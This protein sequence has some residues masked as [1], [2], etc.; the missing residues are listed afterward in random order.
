MLFGL[1]TEQQ[2]SPGFDYEIPSPFEPI[3]DLDL[4]IEPSMQSGIGKRAWDHA[5]GGDDN[6]MYMG[7]GFRTDS[8]VGVRSGEGSRFYNSTGVV[9]SRNDPEA[10]DGSRGMMGMLQTSADYDDDEEE[11]MLL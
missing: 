9:Y 2:N 11:E 7:G 1:S 5:F 8:W 10:R 6:A 4:D 3:L